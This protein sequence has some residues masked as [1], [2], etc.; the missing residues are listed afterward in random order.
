MTEATAWAMTGLDLQGL[1]LVLHVETSLR[2]P[3]AVG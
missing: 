3:K 1:S 2:V